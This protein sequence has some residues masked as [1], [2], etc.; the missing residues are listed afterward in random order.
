M[1]PEQRAPG[2]ASCPPACFLR[3]PG[4]RRPRG[5]GGHAQPAH[6]PAASQA[7]LWPRLGLPLLLTPAAPSCRPP[8]LCLPGPGPAVACSGKPLLSP[9]SKSCPPS[10]IPPLPVTGGFR[11]GLSLTPGRGEGTRE[12][13]GTLG[14]GSAGSPV[15]LRD[16]PPWAR[17]WQPSAPLHPQPGLAQPPGPSP[18]RLV[19]LTCPSALP[20][21]SADATPPLRKASLGRVRLLPQPRVQAGPPSGGLRPAGL[22]LGVSFASSAPSRAT[23]HLLPFAA[24]PPQ[25]GHAHSGGSMDTTPG[26]PKAS[27]GP[28]LSPPTSPRAAARPGC[29][30]PWTP[31]A[32]SRPG[33]TW[34]P[35][36]SQKRGHAGPACGPEKPPCL[37]I[38]PQSPA[39]LSTAEP[40]G[41][42]VRRVSWPSTAAPPLGLG[43]RGQV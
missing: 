32:I 26:C 11:R 36:C 27:P 15:P 29:G 20:H 35:G 41:R 37:G 6:T 9:Q 39:G 38:C 31:S 24:P 4:P 18:G 17:C 3:A 2:P 14:R 13:R 8:G 12:G 34:A 16:H 22:P 5:W 23:P 19:P 43:L 28:G 40:R 10:W 42:G 7:Q 30:S 25:P 21:P 1:G 33:G